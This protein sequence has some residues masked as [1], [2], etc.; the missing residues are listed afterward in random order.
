MFTP[1]RASFGTL[2]CELRSTRF[3]LDAAKAGVADATAMTGTAHAEVSSS[4]RRATVRIS[5][6]GVMVEDFTVFS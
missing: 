2:A 6:V 3:S 4:F 5:G 1:L